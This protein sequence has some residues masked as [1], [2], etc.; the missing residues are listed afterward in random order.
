MNA[1]VGA[2]ERLVVML[3]ARISEFEKRMAKAEGTGTRAYQRLRRSSQGATQQMEADMNR[4]SGRIGQALSSVTGQIGSFGKGLVGGLA[5]GAV[6]MAL[7]SITSDLAATVKG[8]AAVGDEA[9]RSGLGLQAFQEWQFVAE[10]NRVSIDA[11]VDGFKELSLRADEY[12]V[13]GAGSAAEA[14]S[15]LGFRAADLKERLK[16]PSALMLEIIDRLQRLD[17]AAR[18]RIADEIF[19]G[20]GGE[21]FV[22]LIDQG[23]NGLR[24]TIDRAH[25]VGRVMDQAM[26]EKAAELDRKWSELT[27]RVATFGRTLAV[28]IADVPFDV[29]ETRLN[30]IFTEAE[31]RNILGEDTYQTL[32]DMGA[33]TDEQVQKLTALR[34]EYV[35]LEEAARLAS[36]Q[37]AQAAGQADMM[38]NDDLWQV[39][40]DAS[41][42]LR[43][44]ADDFQSGAI[45]G[46]VFR[47]KM[48]EVQVK[49]RDAFATMDAA[50]RVNF[51]PAISEV[52][53]L[54]QVIS[55]VAERAKALYGW[56]RAAANL[57]TSSGYPVDDRGAAIV[58]SRSGSYANSSPLAPTASPRP[59]DKPFE[60]GFPELPDAS[61]G[62]GGK[63]KDQFADAMA[64]AEKQIAMLN[65]ETAAFLD[66]AAAGTDYGAMTEYARKKAE[67]LVAAQQ[68]GLTVT[69]ELTA[70]IEAQ[71]KAYATAGAEAEAARAQIE[72]I[73]AQSAKGRDALRGVFDAIIEGSGGAK[74]AVA[75]LLMEIAKVQ[76]SKGML[77]LIDS[78]GGGGLVSGLG[79]LLTFEG[80]GYTG[81]GARS[82]GMDG[83]GGFLAMVHPRETIIDRAK[84]PAQGSAKDGMGRLSV[85]VSI[86]GGGNLLAIIRNEAGIVLAEGR[87]TMVKQSVK[88]SIRANRSSKRFFG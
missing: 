56:V 33:L 65:A 22:Q 61:S 45:T 50:D 73:N 67:L 72:Q 81:N 24:R 75:S 66:A 62:G 71:A 54:G 8:I 51:S 59:R 49:T 18:I 31:G 9:K 88:A 83:K 29:L 36:N 86:D 19:G 77:R 68:Q 3:E 79:S 80:G 39:L 34:A 26:I 25:E 63:P 70:Q 17:Q 57:D 27:D 69:P 87:E 78:M 43:Q 37:M 64:Q 52:D 53:R 42:Q 38:G 15:R 82:G 20:T 44:L 85:G 28:A 13:T 6:S 84:A 4:A 11:L 35:G 76:F 2:D 10:Q 12:I 1:A 40:A 14:F 74:E 32:R 48:E 46:E 30:E 23:E 7:S 41:N 60:L 16:D 21:Q 47:A 5:V 55:T 58:E